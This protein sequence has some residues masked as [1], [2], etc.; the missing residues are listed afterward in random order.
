MTQTNIIAEFGT[1][2]T[3]PKYIIEYQDK[4]GEWEN[5]VG[6]WADNTLTISYSYDNQDLAT[7]WAKKLFTISG[8]PC[9]VI[10]VPAERQK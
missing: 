8:T 4:A 6:L 9:R 2:E 7:S 3:M 10:E 1:E 5:A